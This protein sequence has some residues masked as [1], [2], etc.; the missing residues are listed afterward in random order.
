MISLIESRLDVI[1]S[2]VAKMQGNQAAA[3]PRSN[4]ENRDGTDEDDGGDDDSASA[5]SR[6]PAFSHS[7]LSPS[8]SRSLS[9]TSPQEGGGADA[10][11]TGV[12]YPQPK[13]APKRRTYQ[14]SAF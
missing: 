9:S 10:Q 1:E 13:F 4:A 11:S 14:R 3:L 6:T 2:Q 7:S 12:I 8:S 5:L